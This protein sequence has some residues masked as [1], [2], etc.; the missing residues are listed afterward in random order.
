MDKK[1]PQLC[2]YNSCTACSACANICKH[3][4]ISMSEDNHGEH[5]PLIDKDKT[6][7]HPFSAPDESCSHRAPDPLDIWG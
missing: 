3:G 7:A 2:S 4:A 1:R 6:A 5:Y